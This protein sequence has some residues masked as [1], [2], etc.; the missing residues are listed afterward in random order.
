[1]FKYGTLQ[2]RSIL[3]PQAFLEIANLTNP[4]NKVIVPAVV[5]SGAT[6]TCIPE[7]IIAKLG[8]RAVAVQIIRTT[9][10]SSSMSER[11][12]YVIRAKITD[13]TIDS[14]LAFG[15]H[16]IRVFAIQQLK[17]A[18]IG[19]DILNQF[20]VVLNAP[21]HNWSLHNIEHSVENSVEEPVFKSF[22]HKYKNELIEFSEDLR[23][24]SQESNKNITEKE[25]IIKQR[26]DWIQNR[27]KEI[28]EV[29]QADNTVLTVVNINDLVK[30]NILS[31]SSIQENIDITEDY[32]N[33][34][35]SIQ[36]NSQEIKDVIY[37]LVNNAVEAIK[38]SNKKNKQIKIKTHITTLDYINYIQVIIEDNGI[39][40]II[41]GHPDPNNRRLAERLKANLY[42]EKSPVNY[43]QDIKEIVLEILKYKKQI[44]NSIIDEQI[45]KLS[46]NP[47]DIDIYEELRKLDITSQQD[48]N[49][50]AYEKVKQDPQWLEKYQGKYVAFVEEKLVDYDVEENKDK[51]RKRIEKKY[52][53]PTMSRFLIKVEPMEDEIIDLPSSLWFDDLGLDF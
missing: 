11:M 49:I 46:P 36:I 15:Y 24:L 34:I 9:G 35:P 23:K 43:R 18:L 17:Y 3:S 48:P 44:V 2:H 32:D 30:E 7:S 1:M 8:C 28:R 33:S 10:F 25:Q 21:Q 22:L 41:T 4:E 5:D 51:I 16:E 45:A 6:I 37:N 40:I 31:F 39:G 19:R 47:K 42:K 26:L 52:P 20:K 13:T 50:I 14:S 53:N 27:V 38:K 12:L 29:F